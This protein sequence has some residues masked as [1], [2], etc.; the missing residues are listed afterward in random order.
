MNSVLRS[1]RATAIGNPMKPGLA[2]RKHA[3]MVRTD[4]PT[5][6]TLQCGLLPPIRVEI[7]FVFVILVGFQGLT[8][9]LHF[10]Y[11]ISSP[12]HQEVSHAGIPTGPGFP[13]VPSR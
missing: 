6:I 8:Y 9:R 3:R 13:M 12:I 5:N 10:P 1:D 7:G 4:N 2:A 11:S